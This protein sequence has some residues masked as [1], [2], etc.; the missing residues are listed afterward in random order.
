M[1]D[2]VESY[3]TDDINQGCFEK[4]HGCISYRKT[5]SITIGLSFEKN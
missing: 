4:Y 2:L 1:R 5:K 3:Y